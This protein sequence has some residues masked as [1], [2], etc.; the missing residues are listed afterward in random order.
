MMTHRRTR[1]RSLIAA[2]VGALV[3]PAQAFADGEIGEHVQTY[4]KHMDEYAA[5]VDR[6]NSALDDLVAEAEAGAF[7]E[8]DV[9]RLVEVWEDVKVHG[10]I[11]VVATP[12]YPPIWEGIYALRDAAA[13]TASAD[14]VASAA[15]QTSVALHEGLGALRL[16]TYQHEIGE[17]PD[18][19]GRG[20]PADDPIH[21]I[22]DRLS[23]AVAKYQEGHA[24]D[25]KALIHD[26]YFNYF[27]GIEG[28]LIEQDAALV[29]TLEE[30]FNG[31]LPNL[32]N[33]GASVEDIRGQVNAMM[34]K[35]HRAEDLLAKA[36]NDK[37][38][39]F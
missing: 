23:Q 11:E 13:E 7:D 10:A 9:D 6:M 22:E 36:E 31:A 29:T 27:E 28:A 20:A 5:G 4:W 21:A 33:R 25:A 2:A 34:E 39:V 26:A 1:T 24:D 3:L 14:A 15:E 16:A 18:L 12:L 8:A 32:I 37:G 17:G 19:A 38:D 35:L 30:D